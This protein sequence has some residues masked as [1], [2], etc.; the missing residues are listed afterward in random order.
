MLFSSRSCLWFLSRRLKTFLP[1]CL[2]TARAGYRVRPTSTAQRRT[3]TSLNLWS[4]L[5]MDF[6]LTHYR[7]K[8]SFLFLCDYLFYESL[9]IICFIL[10][11]WIPFEVSIDLLPSMLQLSHSFRMILGFGWTLFSMVCNNKFDLY[12]KSSFIPFELSFSTLVV[13]NWLKLKRCIFLQ[14]LPSSNKLIQL[15]HALEKT[16][17]N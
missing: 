2:S 7:K 14:E 3:R 1:W 15:L 16:D 10:D 4:Y 5:R 8:F 9:A 17:L 11:R 12:C 6:V 13:V